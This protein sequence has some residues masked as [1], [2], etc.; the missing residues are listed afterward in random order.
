MYSFSHQLKFGM[1]FTSQVVK[2]QVAYLYLNA[3]FSKSYL[4]LK[5]CTVENLDI[6]CPME[7]LDV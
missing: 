7:S 1:P 2:S 5:K 6:G 4:Y 3:Q